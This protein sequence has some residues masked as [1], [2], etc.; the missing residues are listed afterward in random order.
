MVIVSFMSLNFSSIAEGF[1]P[2]ATA[3]GV[4]L[5]AALGAALGMPVE[6]LIIEAVNSAT[7]FCEPYSQYQSLTR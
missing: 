5:G 4:A 3:L 1:G 6:K 7:S 2:A